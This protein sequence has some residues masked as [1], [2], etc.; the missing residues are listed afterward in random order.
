[1]GPGAP[2]SNRSLIVYGVFDETNQQIQWRARH[3][4]PTVRNQDASRL[5]LRRT[6]RIENQRYGDLPIVEIF[7]PYSYG[8]VC[9]DFLIETDLDVVQTNERAVFNTR[10]VPQ[11]ASGF[12]L[13]CGEAIVTDAIGEFASTAFARKNPEVR[14]AFPVLRSPVRDAT[15]IKFFLTPCD[16][17][18]SEEHEM[19]QR[20][21][22][23]M[24][25]EPAYC[26]DDWR[27]SN[28]IGALSADFARAIE[29]QRPAGDDMVLVIGL[30]QDQAGVSGAVEDALAE[31][32][33]EEQLRTSPRLA[34]AFVLDSDAR[35]LTRTEIAPSTLWCPS[36]IPTD[37]EAIPDAS[38]RSC[39]IAPDNPAFDLGPFS[40]SGLPIL[41]SREQYLDFIDE[42]S[43]NQAGSIQ[44]LTYRAPEFATIADS[45]PFGE[46]G[47][48]TFLNNEIISTDEDDAFSF[49]VQEDSIRYVFRT[50]LM[51]SGEILGLLGVECE[52]LGLPQT[53]CDGELA[54]PLE[55][56]AEW[57]QLVGEDDYQMGLFWE[58]PF[59]L[60]AEYESV[61]AVSATAFGFTVP[62]GF[63]SDAE[64]FYGT[65]FWQQQ[66]FPI[67]NS[68]D[69]CRRFC[70]NPTFDSA[71]VYRIN[72][73]FRDTYA[74]ACFNPTFPVLG[75][76]GFPRDP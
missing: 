31:V 19:M 55:N 54:L 46:F 39:A 3:Q 56:I 63:A 67:G 40:F 37:P 69:Q 5:G 32:L 22:L 60:R 57:H 10:A 2:H 42:F 11:A 29:A 68:L 18:I 24:E 33:A 66:N 49:C 73:P 16:R 75:D 61:A 12:A 23:Q 51:Q 45:I 52:K 8:Q 70:D 30:H 7:N 47:T 44:T 58:F 21:R 28:F 72:E 71:G 15:P 6:F 38:V 1:V 14:E 17:V 62:F 13:V 64:S 41:P 65:E 35:G 20:Q 9:P 25:N 50:E 27:S 76:S 36:V 26:I 4:F 43:P 53:F 48:I 34:G 74:R 59:L